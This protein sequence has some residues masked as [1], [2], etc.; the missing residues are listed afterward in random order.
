L[1]IQRFRLLAVDYDGTLTTDG[2][3]THTTVNALRTARDSGRK[4]VLV[5]GRMLPDLQRNFAEGLDLFDRVVAENGATLV[6]PHSGHERLLA[7]P[8]PA[9]L[10]TALH[11]RGVPFATGRVIVA[12]SEP[13]EATA[14]E[15]I[16]D[17]GLE[18]QLIFNKGAVM[19]L[20]VGVS[21]ASG[22]QA[23][24]DELGLSVHNTVG[25]G[26]A[27]NDRA[28]LQLC[29]CSVAVANALRS[30]KRRADLVTR[31]AQGE[32]V[33]E[34]IDQLLADDLASLDRLK[35]HRI[36]LGRSATSQK[37]VALSPFGTRLLVSGAS[38]AGKSS[39]T[40]GLVEQ[41]HAHGYQFCLVDPEGDYE[42]LPDTVT[43]GDTSQA[44][45]PDDVLEVL[46][47]PGQNVCVSMLA[48][49]GEYRPGYFS[50]LLSAV[51]SLA[52]ETGRPHWL[53]VDEAHHVMP[54]DA[55]ERAP[56]G[57][58]NIVLVTL[59]PERVNPRAVAEM[60]AVL[61]LGKAPRRT[62][63]TAARLLGATPPTT[64]AGDLKRGEGVLWRRGKKRANLVNLIRPTLKR[65]RH[66]RKYSEGEL[67]P[68]QSFYFRGPDNALNLRAAN[69][70]EFVRFAEGLDDATWQYHLM[71]GD[72]ARWVLHS[73]KDR[74]LA[75]DITRLAASPAAT[76]PTQSRSEVRKLIE[77][78]YAPPD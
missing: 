5:T 69:L 65:R 20:P 40:L 60:N 25:I 61:A 37:P 43:Q 7:D 68:E 29:E 57:I 36:V 75:R 27:E 13:H 62:V 55:V 73:L 41:L 49:A 59:E 58:A 78:R 74:T 50:N 71:A 72:Y 42:R 70:Q 30:V 19:I 33:A 6:D 34:L 76:N 22:L 10:T 9:E 77:S 66:R 45:T 46:R 28:F 67:P 23:A 48:V 2:L 54:R 52:A 56:D 15:A 51:Q 16:H 64:P 44:P 53:I 4:L 38:Q 35:R 21:K 12:T 31:G 18:L 11:E 63:A 3:V 1:G 39:L 14:L 47:R 17:L 8:P 26:D 24:L 32:G